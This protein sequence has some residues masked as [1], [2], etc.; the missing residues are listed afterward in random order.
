VLDAEPFWEFNTYVKFVLVC[1]VL[2]IF[3]R[4]IAP[5]YQ[6][7]GE[8]DREFSRDIQRPRLSQREE[9]EE[10]IAW[11]TKKDVIANAM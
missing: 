10:S 8:V 6:T 3:L 5:N 4:G 1:C 2:H 7:M 11:K 9:Q